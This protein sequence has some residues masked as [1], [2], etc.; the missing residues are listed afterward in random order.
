MYN[1]WTIAVFLTMSG[2]S[3]AI[4]RGYTVQ[5]VGAYVLVQQQRI[6]IMCQ[7]LNEYDPFEPL[8]VLELD[9]SDWLYDEPMTDYDW[10][11]WLENEE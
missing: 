6:M 5:Y 3:P 11:E 1:Q 10:E 7:D 4:F 2:Y 8:Y 9:G